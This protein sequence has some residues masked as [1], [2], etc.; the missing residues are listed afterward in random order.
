MVGERSII[1]IQTYRMIVASGGVIALEL[2]GHSRTPASWREHGMRRSW[3]PLVVMAI[4]ILV[5]AMAAAGSVQA[6][7]P[8]TVTAVNKFSA[9]INKSLNIE[10]RFRPGTLHIQHGATLTFREGPPQPPFATPV[11]PHTL[12]IVARADL[13]GTLQELFECEVCGPFLQAHDLEGAS[14]KFVVNEGKAGL[15][16]PG[17]SLLVTDAHPVTRARVTAPAGTTLHYLCAVHSWMQGKLV[18]E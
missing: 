3:R 12:S 10:F 9:Q 4:T 1:R 18:V 16:Q 11:D 8:N 2:L 13:P 15:D 6:S 14:P 17:D 5:M 7:S